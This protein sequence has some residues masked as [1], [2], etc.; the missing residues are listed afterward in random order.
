MEESASVASS[1]RMMT[2]VMRT[3]LRLDRRGD[4]GNM[5]ATSKQK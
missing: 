5:A 4:D 3:L 1:G 2:S